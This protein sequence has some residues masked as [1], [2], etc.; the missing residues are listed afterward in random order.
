VTSAVRLEESIPIT[1]EINASVAETKAS[2]GAYNPYLAA[3][4]EWDERYGNL[5]TRARNW[6]LMA[7]LSALVALFSVGGMIR[8][9]AKSHI[10]PF[11]VAIDSLG[12]T[13]AAGTAD[14]TSSSDDRLKRATLFDW[15]EDLRTVTTDGIAQ[16]KAIDRVYS[17]IASGGQAQT[18]ISEFYRS[19]PPQ[20]RAETETVSVEVQSVLPT[21]DRT[22]E[23]EWVETTRDLYGAVKGQDHWKAAFSIAVN[24]P[25]DER[26]A[27]INPLGIYVTNASWSKVL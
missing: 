3:R 2:E 1:Q 5:I 19:D 17:H 24:P 4:R 22:F 18:F 27:R 14:E 16:R 11:V 25:T 26:L 9:S 13:A 23:V 10:V 20:Q 15:L 12:R 8:L 21:S 7:I 6:R